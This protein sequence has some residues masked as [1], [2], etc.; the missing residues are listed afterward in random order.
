MN[1]QDFAKFAN[2]EQIE[3]A[4]K[5]GQQAFDNAYA[6]GKEAARKAMETSTENF[7][8]AADQFF[9]ATK[10]GVSKVFPQ[11]TTMIDQ[12]IAFNRANMEAALNA[13]ATAVKG[14]E[15]ITDNLIAYGKKTAEA[16]LKIA[17]EFSKVNSPKDFADIQSKAAREAVDGF[18]AESQKVAE[19]AAKTVTEAT[20]PLQ[21]RATA[22]QA[23]AKEAASNAAQA[24]A[25]KTQAA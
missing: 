14:A 22:A 10:D 6:A 20:Q 18:V 12:A 11:S 8:K 15:A 16:N 23:E 9:G 5:A 19:I 21:E 4:Y 3:S 7:V 1:P 13:S 2:T 24:A 17:S 25:P